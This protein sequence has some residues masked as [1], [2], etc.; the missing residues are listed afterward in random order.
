[1]RELS[2]HGV[3]VMNARLEDVVEALAGQFDAVV[4]R[5]AGRLDELAASAMRLLAPGGVII[6][7]GPPEESDLEI[8]EWVSV[9]LD[10]TAP[11]RRFAVYRNPSA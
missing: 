11:P 3:R 1:V 10:P 4:M 2:L 5:C 9:R 6:A 7:S 8:G